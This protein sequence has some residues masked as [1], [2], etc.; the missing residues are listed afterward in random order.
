[1]HLL[2]RCFVAKMHAAATVVVL[3]LTSLS[4]AI[5]N[6]WFYSQGVPEKPR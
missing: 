1:M 2:Q 6:N 5:L 4:D 3:A